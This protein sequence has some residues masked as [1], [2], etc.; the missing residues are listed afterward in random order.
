MAFGLATTGFGAVEDTFTIVVTGTTGTR[1]ILRLKAIGNIT[2]GAIDGI[3]AIGNKPPP[4]KG[5]YFSIKE[6]FRTSES[7]RF[8]S[9]FRGLRSITFFRAL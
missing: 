1:V 9:P 4:L 8:I 2:T 5:S 6:A 7:F 3:K